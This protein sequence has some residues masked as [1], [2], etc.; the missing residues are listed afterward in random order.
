MRRIRLTAVV[1]ILAIAFGSA[2]YLERVR[3][4]DWLAAQNAPD[5]PASVTYAEVSGEEEEPSADA[6]PESEEE[7]VEVVPEPGVGEEEEAEIDE[8]EVSVPAEP[9]EGSPEV[10][11]SAPETSPTSST[12]NDNIPI[13]FNLAVPFTS[14][15]P[16]ANW[17]EVHEETCEEAS[18]YMVYLYYQ[19]EPEGQV[20][21]S[22]ADTE[23]LRIVDFENELFGFYK[24]T[25][26]EQTAILAEQMYG[27]TRTEILKN[28]TAED[29]KRHVAAGRPVIVPAAGRMLRNP[30][31]SGE[32]PIYHMFV[33]RGYTATSFIANDPGTR[34]GEN[35]VYDIDT[36]MSA[37]HDWNDGD[38]YNGA[39]VVLVVY[40]E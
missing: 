25:T 22:T 15:A 8:E 11:P 4:S 3:I 13:E 12:D 39:K 20:D 9:V 19:G 16:F 40:P 33:I 28:P 30:N 34:R 37:I 14:Q 32:G 26:A 10:A 7:D 23:L 29:I 5:V 35:Y 1:V 38:V 18:L 2:L 24:D 36:I 27:Y 17:D 31:F 21:A 6:E